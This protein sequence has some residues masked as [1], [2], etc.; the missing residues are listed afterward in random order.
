MA[1][2]TLPFQ[3]GSHYHIIVY[4]VLPSHAGFLR[5]RAYG[6]SHSLYDTG[7]VLIAGSVGML[8]PWTTVIA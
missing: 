8:I 2:V 5:S 3:H 7:Y 6:V 1:T 4:L